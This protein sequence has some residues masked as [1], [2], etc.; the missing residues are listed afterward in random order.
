M[1][2][3]LGFIVRA[4]KSANPPLVPSPPGSNPLKF[5][6][7]GA[8][9]I[10]P[11]GIIKPARSHPDAV[12]HAIAARSKDRAAAYARTHG[13][14]KSFGSYE[15]LLSDPEIDA[16]YIA[17]P[18]GLHFEWTMKA[19]AAGKHV[20]VEKPAAATSEEVRAMFEL[21]EEKNLVLL[22]GV[23]SRFH[24]AN[25]RVKEIIDSGELG[26]VKGTKATLTLPA[27]TIKPDDAR[28]DLA[29]G[30]G[31]LLD[32]GCYTVTATRYY[33]GQEP[34]A[35]TSVSHT[36]ASTLKNGKPD[37]HLVDRQTTATFSLPANITSTIHCDL[38]APLPLGFVP[39]FP[40][41][42]A[43][44][45][46]AN[47]NIQVLNYVSP[48]M[49]H[50]ITVTNGGKK[51]VEKHY[52]GPGGF[53]EPWWT[54]FRYQLE[55]FVNQVRGRPVHAWISGADSVANIQA[56]ESIYVKS[57]LGVRPKSGWVPV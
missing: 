21:A 46:C 12:V 43:K 13:I 40:D 20:L 30:G 45:E 23:H 47:G 11:E 8:A 10:A 56:I 15:E 27:G 24:P 5:G 42:T 36:L 39:I 26:P 6:I 2:S 29:L 35:V 44:I 22:E 7:L 3:I 52:T 49:Y 51:R 18:T 57:G 31:A 1:S 38:I 33:T 48:T 28:F 16:I 14:P 54:S 41:L 32:A 4:R 55:A 19:L 37:Q 9:K 53:G 34:T 25:L 17:L 50:S